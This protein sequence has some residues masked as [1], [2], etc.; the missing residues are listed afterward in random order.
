MNKKKGPPK[1]EKGIKIHFKNK[2][3]KPERDHDET[4][5]NRPQ[6]RKKLK[7]KKQME[8]SLLP[9]LKVWVR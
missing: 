4:A 1:E 6:H 7:R 5:V 3:P 8:N 2:K 9:G